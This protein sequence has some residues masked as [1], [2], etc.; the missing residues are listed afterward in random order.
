[1][2][3]LIASVADSG[4]IVLLMRVQQELRLV[5]A[6]CGRGKATKKITRTVFWYATNNGDRKRSIDRNGISGTGVARGLRGVRV[7]SKA[8]K[9]GSAATEDISE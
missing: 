2:A 9:R 3:G 6:I 8:S 4:L 1:M 5:M 7:A